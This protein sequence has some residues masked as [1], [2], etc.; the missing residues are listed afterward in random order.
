MKYVKSFKALSLT[1][2][3]VPHFST[4][5]VVGHANDTILGY[6]PPFNV[7]TCLLSYLFSDLSQL[8]MSAIPSISGATLVILS[9][10]L[11]FI[12]NLFLSHNLRLACKHAWDQTI[13]S[14]GKGPAFWQ[15]Y[16]EEWDFP[17]KIDINQWAGLEN[18][19]KK[20]LRFAVK[21]CELALDT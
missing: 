7:P 13:A 12:F 8:V 15:P 1:V 19:K 9:S 4:T 21:H 2:I 3:Y 14:R 6:K 16:I 17:P 10:Q 5:N 11:T 18:V 20:L